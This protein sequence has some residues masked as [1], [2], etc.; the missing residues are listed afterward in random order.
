MGSMNS[1]AE[2]VEVYVVAVPLMAG[3]S[4]GSMALAP[5]SG[6]VGA[7]MATVVG[8]AKRGT[9]FGRNGFCSAGSEGVKS[10]KRPMT[11]VQ[12]L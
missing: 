8:D 12:S 6:A 3:V 5:S 10:G 4:M 2:A 9:G 7:S 11:T 1:L